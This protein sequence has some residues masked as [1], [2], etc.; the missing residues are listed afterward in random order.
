MCSSTS[1]GEYQVARTAPLSTAH[2]ADD[3]T[4]RNRRARKDR[5][6]AGR[7][8]NIR[9]RERYRVFGYVLGETLVIWEK[10]TLS[11]SRQ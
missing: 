10:P 5:W 1:L 3:Q 11:L 6:L 8:L 9:A 2:L 4:Q 7:S